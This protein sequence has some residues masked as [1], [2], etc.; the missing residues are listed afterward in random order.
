MCEHLGGLVSWGSGDLCLEEL[1]LNILALQ[2]SCQ[3]LKS[4][5]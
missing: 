4:V 3:P 5:T 1:L 2:H